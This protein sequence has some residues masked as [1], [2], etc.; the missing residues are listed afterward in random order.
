MTF[1]RMEGDPYVTRIPSK[2]TRAPKKQKIW[3]VMIMMKPMC[4]G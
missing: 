1:P 4:Q 3:K 2:E